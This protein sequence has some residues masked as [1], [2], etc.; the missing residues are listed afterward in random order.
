[1]T[2]RI[3]T[4]AMI[5]A[6]MKPKQSYH[7]RGLGETFGVTSTT[8]RHL[9]RAAVGD[10][11]IEGR[12]HNGVR[13]YSLPAESAPSP[14]VKP[15]TISREMRAAMERCAELRIHPSKH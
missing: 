1:M 6:A 5:R 10:G 8:M 11:M 14:A 15:L 9:L 12:E 3:I 2:E 13:L 4:S 7:A